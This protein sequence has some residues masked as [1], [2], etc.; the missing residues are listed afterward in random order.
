MHTRSPSKLFALLPLALMTSPSLQAATDATLDTQIITAQA[1]VSA[2]RHPGSVSVI[3]AGEIA[4]S[5]AS[6]LQDL[7]QNLPGVY[8]Q[9]AGNVSQQAP[10]I[11]GFAH[12]QTLVLVDG[13]RVP[14]TDRNL[15]FEPAYRYNWVPVSQIERVEVIRGPAAT[16]YGADAMAGVINIIT[17]KAGQ[18]WN[19]SLDGDLGYLD[20]DHQSDALTASVSGPLGERGDLSLSLSERNE[21]PIMADN[22]T[23]LTSELRSRNL[24]ADLGFDLTARDRIEFGLM[25]GEDDARE[26][27]ASH[28]FGFRETKLE[29]ERR[30][31]T[32]DYLTRLG[33]FDLQLSANQGT[34][35]ILEGS[36]EWQVDEDSY[37]LDLNGK[38]ADQHRLSAGLQHR[39]EDVA[40]KDKNFNDGV[41][42]TSLTFQDRIGL[43]DEHSLTLGLAYDHHSRYDAELSSSLYWNWQNASG[44]GLKAGYGE[45]YMAPGLS[46]A[47]SSYV[48]PA[49]PFR[50]YEGNDNLQP[51]TN[52]T[53]EIGVSYANEGIGASL[54]LFHNDIEN[55]I[56]LDEYQ[57]GMV[58]VAQY[59]NVDQAMTRGLEA[60][61]DLLP[62]DN[63]R[64]RMN[65]T[66]LESE[67]RS[68]SNSGKALVDTPEHLFKLVA[69]HN[70]SQLN[71]TLY[72]AWRYTGS[73]YTNGSNSEKMDSYQ[74][75]DLGMSTQLGQHARVRFGINNLFD[76]VVEEGG[77]L[78][79]AGR[80][81]KVSLSAGF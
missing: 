28:G 57:D 37:Q 44:W 7:L 79:E 81:L 65:Y 21:E 71:S 9:S 29:Q 27:G 23:T 13:K 49:G 14:N 68:G 45:S 53:Y 8:M 39:R 25:I 72:G 12:E 54:T 40:R 55:K 32:A 24:H 62:W 76:E 60:E 61:L 56:G 47:T 10:S 70:L 35:D 4:R 80:E 64:L 19:A 77:E 5:G 15:S 1:A 73:Q 6:S 48:L 63:G 30:I 16:L 69:E 36:S 34:T 33:A 41:H 50:R 51:E 58:T 11:R 74:V 38:A 26:I 52:E 78:L 66:W 43:T 75:V 31:W 18:Q 17:K 3:D 46:R 42:A 59:R 20:G 67:N 2:T 22:G